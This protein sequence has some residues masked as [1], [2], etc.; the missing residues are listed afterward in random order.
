[1]GNDV[2]RGVSGGER[3]RVSIAELLTTGCKLGCHDNSSRGLDASSALEYV[4]ALKVAT[5][6]GRLTSVL[7]L[8]QAGE[9]L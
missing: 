2:V 6:I 1:M 4:S 9:Q 3:K 5:K 8:Y 7:S